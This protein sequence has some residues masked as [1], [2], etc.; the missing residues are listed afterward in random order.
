MPHSVRRRYA[1][2]AGFAFLFYIAAGLAETVLFSDAV[3]GGTASAKL[4]NVLLHE[5]QLRLTV[6]LTLATVLSALALAVSLF[7]VTR[8][9]DPG[10]ALIGLTGRVAEGVLGAVYAL[11]GLGLLSVA[12]ALD[13]QQ[14]DHEAEV[15]VALLVDARHNLMMLSA[16]CFAAGSL[17]FSWLLLTGRAV[18]KAV[19]WW[20]VLASALLLLALPVQIAV[21]ARG[22][23]SMLVWIPMLLFEIVLAVW[24]MV[25][26]VAP[27]G[28]AT[29]GALS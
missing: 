27:N 12:R 17:A 24:L 5:T 15:L 4:T 10:L 7:V 29:P 26:G 20:G 8:D 1:R 14:S 22:V 11:P 9:F 2:L 3:G 23:L 28:G 16:V 6:V 25:R 19:A 21:N 13:G 18:P